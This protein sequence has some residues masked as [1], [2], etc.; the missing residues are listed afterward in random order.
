MPTNGT[1]PAGT[2][3]PTLSVDNVPEI[4]RRLCS[5]LGMNKHDMLAAAMDMFLA[6]TDPAPLPKAM[7]FPEFQA[8]LEK[9]KA[10]T[11][12]PTTP[13]AELLAELHARP[14]TARF[15]TRET[16]LYGN[17]SRALLRSWRW[18]RKGPAFSGKGKNVR[19]TKASIDKFIAA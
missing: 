5:D 12:A 17:W 2:D 13:E 9:L 3:R 14:S 1:T 4:F 6:A 19:Y 7:P 15:T 18:K 16:A 10:A 11:E 8:G